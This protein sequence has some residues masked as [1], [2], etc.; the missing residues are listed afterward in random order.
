MVGLHR[1]V[2]TAAGRFSQPLSEAH[3]M[4]VLPQCSVVREEPVGS[5]SD[6]DA[7]SVV[8]DEVFVVHEGGEGSVVLDGVL[9]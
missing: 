4:G 8:L 9:E 5:R 7:Q 2:R 1:A 6:D 3:C